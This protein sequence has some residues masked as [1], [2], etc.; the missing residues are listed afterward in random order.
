[1]VDVKKGVVGGAMDEAIV[2]GDARHLFLGREAGMPAFAGV[3]V[4]GI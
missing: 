2:F 1:V 4:E 3:T